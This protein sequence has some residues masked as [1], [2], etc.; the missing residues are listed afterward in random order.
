MAKSML[1][2]NGLSKQCLGIESRSYCKEGKGCAEGTGTGDIDVE[3]YFIRIEDD[4]I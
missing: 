2:H 3:S 1:L 4:V